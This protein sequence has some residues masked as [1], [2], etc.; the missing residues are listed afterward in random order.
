MKMDSIRLNQLIEENYQKIFL[1]ALK[2][3]KNY[4]D[5]EDATQEIFLKV[6]ENISSFRQEAK[7]TTWIYRIALNHIYYMSTKRSRE[8]NQFPDAHELRTEMNENPSS[9][10]QEK[11]LFESLEKVIDS[12][13]PRQKEVFV[14]RY[15]NQ[16]PFKK[17][18]Q[19]LGKSLGTVKSNY[20][21]AMQKIKINLQ[22]QNLINFQE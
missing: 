4:E 14:M 13:S 3:L 22:D 9:V 5:A 7:F 2:M 12:L 20:F 21:F 18:A 16:L 19:V 10:L 17:I 1:L 15:Y 8:L 6:Y 11:E